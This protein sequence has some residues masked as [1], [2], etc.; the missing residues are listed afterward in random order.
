MT[1]S[2]WWRRWRLTLSPFRPFRAVYII[3]LYVV[4]Y[5]LAGWWGVALVIAH[6]FDITVTR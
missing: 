5:W 4:G 6:D 3:S 2:G 1:T